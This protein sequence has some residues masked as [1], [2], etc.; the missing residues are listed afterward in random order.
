MFF[1]VGIG[2][3]DSLD[4]LSRVDHARAAGGNQTRNP[5]RAT[6]FQHIEGSDHIGLVKRFAKRLDS[7]PR[8]GMNDRIDPLAG[9]GNFRGILNVG[10]NK[11]DVDRVRDFD[12]MACENANGIPSFEKSSDNTRSEEPGSPGYQY[13]H[14]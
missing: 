12:P 4:G 2:L 5:C 14:V 6:S 13:F 8:G 1:R 7:F 10:L 3:I 11:L 9:G